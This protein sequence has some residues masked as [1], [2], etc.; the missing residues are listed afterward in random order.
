MVI[1]AITK[2]AVHKNSNPISTPFLWGKILPPLQN[3][4]QKRNSR[5]LQKHNA[6]PQQVNQTLT[7]QNGT[8]IT[9]FKTQ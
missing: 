8:Q 6:V 9:I 2:A 4:Y 3:H 7:P 1:I 5:T